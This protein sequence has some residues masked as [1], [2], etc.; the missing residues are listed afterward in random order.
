MSRIERW[1]NGRK[2]CSRRRVLRVAQNST[3]AEQGLSAGSVGLVDEE[4]RRLVR[5]AVH[6]VD[7]VLLEGAGVAVHETVF[8]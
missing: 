4:V 2:S 7:A 1:S 8:V 3:R 5:R 6:M